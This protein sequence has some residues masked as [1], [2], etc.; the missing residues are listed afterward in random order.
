MVG[1]LMTSEEV[2]QEIRKDKLIY[3][4]SGG[5]VTL[6]GGEVLMQP[7]FAIEILEACQKEKIHTVLDTTAFCRP[8]IFEQVARHI[9]L[10]YVDM[11][12]IDNDLHKKYTA[13][14]N[15]WILHNFQY[16]DANKI[17]FAARM[18]E[19]K[20]TL[21]ASYLMCE[22]EPRFVLHGTEGSYVKYGLDPQEADLTKG[23]LPDTPHWGEEDESQWGILHTEKDGNVVRKPYPTLPGNYAAFY[24]NIYQ[25]IRN[26]E[27]L[28]SDAC[29]VLGVIRL[30]EAAWESSRTGNVIKL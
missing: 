17:P 29:G 9:D 30:I 1:K 7:D 5:G 2:L 10:A 4:R 24:E 8:E 16:L 18:P 3:D 14:D 15:T 11:K 27:V 25:H 22:N 23:V 21:K 13:V 28:Q 20:I 6:S 12:S 26:G 19:V